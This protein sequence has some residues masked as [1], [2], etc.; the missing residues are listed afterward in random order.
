MTNPNSHL[1]ERSTTPIVSVC[2][3]VRNGKP[4]LS[5]QLDSLCVQD[6][7][8]E[9]ELIIADDHS[10]DGTV[11]LANEWKDRLPLTIVSLGPDDEGRERT[12][13]SAGRNT[14]R[15]AASGSFLAFCDADDAVRPDWIRQ[16]VAAAQHHDAVAGVVDGE[17]LNDPVVRTWKPPWPRDR[18]VVAHGMLPSMIGASCGMWADVFDR[19]GGFDE[20]IV[21]G[22]EDI[23]FAWRIQLAG[24]SLSHAP[25]AVVD[26]RYRPTIR[27]LM[28]QAYW[29][30]RS[31]AVMV[32]RY[33]PLV[34]A[35][36]RTAEQPTGRLRTVIT[37][38]PRAVVDRSVRGKLMYDLARATGWIHGKIDLR[39]DRVE[40]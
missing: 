13:P 25:D 34:D 12:G 3:A 36:P 1:N 5:E 33:R 31:A 6:Y 22:H 11:A 21:K 30:Y 27:S 10:T 40:S 17:R 28:V 20:T 23:E 29:R 7:E 38:I 39:R 14:A 2:L 18:L 37:S 15:A 32:D 16:L 4:F 8:G 24:F 26:Y 9:W 35:A 19:A